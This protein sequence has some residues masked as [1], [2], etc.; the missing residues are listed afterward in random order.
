MGI[1]KT[2]LV[3]AMLAAWTA[4][5]APANNLN[6]PLIVFAGCAGRFSAQMEHHWLMGRDPSHVQQ[7]RQDM[8]D[9][10]EAIQPPGRGKEVLARRLEAKYAQAVLLQRAEFTADPVEADHA[11]NHAIS[12]I[13]TCSA[14]LLS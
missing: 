8:I 2:L 9:L 1:L 13:A 6:D 4:G 5:P 10:L 3:S 12:A 11:R 14:L 7:R